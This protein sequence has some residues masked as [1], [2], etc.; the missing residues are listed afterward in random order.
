[1]IVAVI[2]RENDLVLAHIKRLEQPAKQPPCAVVAAPPGGAS[3][4]SVFLHSLFFVLGFTIVFT[5]TG[6]AVGLFGS[7]LELQQPS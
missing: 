7:T 6:V 5:L 4:R 1:M 2:D 3:R